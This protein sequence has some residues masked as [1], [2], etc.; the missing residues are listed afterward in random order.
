MKCDSFIPTQAQPR[1]AASTVDLHEGAAASLAASKQA[2]ANGACKQWEQAV[3]P[4][5]WSKQ[6]AASTGSKQWEKLWVQLEEKVSF[7]DTHK[8]VVI[9]CQK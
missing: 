4:N 1:M 2:A 5:H 6:A 8:A 3:G 7:K 9:L